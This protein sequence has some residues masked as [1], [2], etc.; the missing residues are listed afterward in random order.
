MPL[1]RF[2]KAE[3]SDQLPDSSTAMTISEPAVRGVCRSPS[4]TASAELP[5][6]CK[7][8]DLMRVGFYPVFK[9]P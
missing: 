5:T 6:P 2:W 9:I 1:L 7:L 3:D 8:T 4:F